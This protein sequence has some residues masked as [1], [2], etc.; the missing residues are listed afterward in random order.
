MDT[1]RW[2]ILSTGN[3]AKKFAIGLQSAQNAKLLA[4]GSR[5]QDSAEA[6][7]REF[8]I[9]NVHATYESLV[10]D[11]DV[12]AIYIGTPHVFHADNMKLCL[13]AG[14]HVLCEKPITIN[15]PELEE[16]IALAQEKNL[17]LMEAMWMRFIPA[18]LEIQRLIEEDTIGDIRLIQADFSSYLPFQAEHRAF[19]PHL[20]GGALLDVG[21]YP[22][23]FA[24]F[25]LGMPQTVQSHA[26]I[27]ESGVDEQCTMLFGYPGASALLSAGITGDLANGAVIKGTKGRIIVQSPFWCPDKIT[28][29]I[30]GEEPELR[31]IPYQG[32]G[33]NYEAEAVHRAINAG[34]IEHEIVSHATSIATMQ[35]MDAM[36]RE[37]GLSYPQEE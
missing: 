10:N 19:N 24:T 27:G 2:G 18:I 36:R 37:W 12:D 11:P 25:F 3:I 21:V 4:I 1:L 31:H 23:W 16:C 30:Y 8:D 28:L 26:V 5:S 33:Y 34:K 35:V 32:N 22:I 7:A 13:N 17:F 15:S 9:P 29:H 14:K 20:G 6:F